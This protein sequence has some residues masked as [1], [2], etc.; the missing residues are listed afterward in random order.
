MANANFI[1]LGEATVVVNVVDNTQRIVFNSYYFD[2]QWVIT[3]CTF[4]GSG[5]RSNELVFSSENE[6][7]AAVL[8]I[9]GQFPIK[10][11]LI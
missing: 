9:E 11:K 3:R 2:G 5:S 7:R 6:F 10:G 1:R 8:T 4:D